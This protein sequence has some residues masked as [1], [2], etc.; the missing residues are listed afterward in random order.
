MR[1]EKVKLIKKGGDYIEKKLGSE[2][3]FFFFNDATIR[4]EERNL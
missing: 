2:I 4:F 1:F 3:I